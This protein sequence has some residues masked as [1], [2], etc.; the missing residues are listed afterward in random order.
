VW[1]RHLGGAAD[2]PARKGLHVTEIW[3]LRVDGI[4]GDSKDRK[5]PD[6]IEIDAW[7]WGVRNYVSHG[8]GGGSTGRAELRDLDV[9]M[10]TSIATPLL[11]KACATGQ[12]IRT[13]V[14]TGRRVGGAQFEFLQLTLIDVVVTRVDL[15]DAPATPPGDGVSLG[16]ARAELSYHPQDPSGGSGP[17]ITVTLDPR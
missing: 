3:F 9:T 16:Y 14:L 12:H 13:A 10:R 4:K 8:G 2:P 6:E 5:H 1:W 11:F 17:P 7:G 15:G